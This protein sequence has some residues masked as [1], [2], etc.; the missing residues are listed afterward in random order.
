MRVGVFALPLLKKLHLRC[1][2]RAI[3]KMKLNP[4][5][6]DDFV[7]G[8]GKHILVKFLQIHHLTADF[9]ETVATNIFGIAVF[10][11]NFAVA[12]PM[13][14]QAV[15]PVGS[16]HVLHIVCAAFAAADFRRKTAAA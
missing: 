2:D 12:I 1:L 10:P 5:R 16:Y 13:L 14:Y 4:V 9:A 6:D 7:D 15:M 11:A 3:V 8:L